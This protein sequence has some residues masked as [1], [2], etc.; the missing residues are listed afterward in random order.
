[1]RECIFVY[2]L[3]IHILITRDRNEPNSGDLKIHIKKYYS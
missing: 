1:M 3:M 2:V